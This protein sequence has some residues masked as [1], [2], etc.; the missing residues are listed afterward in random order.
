MLTGLQEPVIMSA[1][2]PLMI[3]TSVIITF[4]RLLSLFR[5]QT[6]RVVSVITDIVIAV[7]AD[8]HPV[9]SIRLVLMI[10]PYYVSFIVHIGMRGAL[11]TALASPV[12]HHT[13][14]PTGHSRFPLVRVM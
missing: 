5:V 6:A 4:S 12:H 13:H 1:D 2:H 11:L 10:F 3:V 9:V 7:I 8:N 14:G